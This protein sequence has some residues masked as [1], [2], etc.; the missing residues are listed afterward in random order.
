MAFRR[1]TPPT[2]T[3][4]SPVVNPPARRRPQA[5][6]DATA[7]P[8]PSRDRAPCPVKKRARKTR[9][10]I[11]KKDRPKRQ[12][13]G[14]Y[15]VGNCRPPPSGQIQP[16]EVRNPKGRPKGA[17]GQ[18]TIRRKLLSEKRTVRIGGKEQ[19]MTVR[20]LLDRASLREALEGGKYPHVAH[21]LAEA[22]RLFPEP[23]SSDAQRSGEV[24]FSA[25]EDLVFQMLLDG[26]SPA[27]AAHL[28]QEG[29]PPTAA[30][31]DNGN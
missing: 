24:V 11:A 27:A 19:S 10:K 7:A 22:R 4:A 29:A 17:S 20:E 2:T 25:A 26:L 3:A 15:E 14:D 30:E 1:V 18:D 21:W 9:T 28:G 31:V 6:A 8:S 16:G 23:P 5:P 12:P 13:T